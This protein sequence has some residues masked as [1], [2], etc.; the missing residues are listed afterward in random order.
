MSKFTP[1]PWVVLPLYGKYYGTEIQIGASAIKVWTGNGEL[2]PSQRELA[3][4]WTPDDGMDH[5]E[6][7]TDYATSRLIAAA[8]EMYDAL[9]ALV[10]SPNTFSSHDKAR[11]EELLARIIG[12]CLA[13]AIAESEGD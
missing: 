9:K 4:G 3:R 10:E 6:T 1:G 12:L 2:C 13:A 8:P 11:A 5:V 7:E